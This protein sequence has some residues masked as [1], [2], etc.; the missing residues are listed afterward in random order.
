MQTEIDRLGRLVFELRAEKNIYESEAAHLRK[1]LKRAA[2][3]RVELLGQ[4]E[5]LQRKP[6]KRSSSIPPMRTSAP[7]HN[8]HMMTDSD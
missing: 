4:M 2:E 7:R 6:T 3:E 1:E 5:I 8:S